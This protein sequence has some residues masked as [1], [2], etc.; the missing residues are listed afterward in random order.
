VATTA[1]P[2]APASWPNANGQ[3]AGQFAGEA[4]PLKTAT[5]QPSSRVSSIASIILR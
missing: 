3:D 2:A 5:P 4:A 1:R